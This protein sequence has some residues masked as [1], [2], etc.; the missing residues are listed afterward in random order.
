MTAMRRCDLK[1][2]CFYVIQFSWNENYEDNEHG[3]GAQQDISTLPL[4]APT[5]ADESLLLRNVYG[6]LALLQATI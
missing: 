6:I 1:Y 5:H 3:G 2:L 4:H